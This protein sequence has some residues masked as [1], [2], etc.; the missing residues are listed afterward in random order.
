MA[1]RVLITSTSFQDNAGSHQELLASL[2]LDVTTRRGP[3]TEAELLPLMGEFDAIICGDDEYTS[4]VLEAATPRLK[5]LS[6]YGIGLD[7]IDLDAAEQLGIPV[8][9]CRGS[10]QVAVAEHFFGLLLSVFRNIPKENQL[11]HDGRW[12]R[13]TGR[14]VR[15][16]ILGILGLGLTGREILKRALAF[17]MEVVG[18]DPVRDPELAALKNF[19][20]LDAPEAVLAQADVLALALNLNEQT[21]GMIDAKRLGLMKRGA[22]IINTARGRLVD[23]EAIRAA[24]DTGQLSAYA[25]DVLEREPLVLPHP[26]IGHDKVI[27]TPHIASRTY[28]SVERQGT[29]AVQNA[30]RHL[31]LL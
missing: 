11:V 3:L 25:T 2:D 16:N 14:E 24:L 22:V 10:N 12:E 30:A 26:L 9:N 13:I 17:E 4:V 6:K 15:G 21:A 8:T 29:V 20:Y 18:F 28:E 31:G 23:P 5:V 7:S 27:I 19:H 1:D